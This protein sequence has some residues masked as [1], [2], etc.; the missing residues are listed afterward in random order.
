MSSPLRIIVIGGDAAGM[1]AASRAR[2]YAP[3]STV[4]VYEAGGHVSYSACGMPFYLGGEVREFD[5]LIHYPVSKFVEER[6]INVELHSRVVSIDVSAKM[7]T[8]QKGNETVQDSYDRLIIASGARPIVPEMFRDRSNVYTLR[9]IDDLLPLEK[10]M[11][12]VQA[13]SIIGAGYVGLEMAEALSKM[14][15]DVTIIQRS[16]RF[17]R[18]IDGDFHPTISKE[19]EANKV[20]L[21]LNSPIHDVRSDEGRVVSIRAGNAEV[22][23]D[24]V[25]VATGVAPNSEFAAQAGIRTGAGGA[26]VVNERM[27]TSAPMVFAAG[28]VATTRHLVTGKDVYFPLATGSNK[29]GRIAGENAAGRRSVYNGI[30][31]TEVVKVFSLEVGR[32]GLTEEEA[33]Q[34]RFRPVSAAITSTSRA[35]YYPGSASLKIK[36]IADENTHRLLGGMLVGKEGVAKR[37]DVLATALYARMRIEDLTRLDYSYSPPFSPSWEPLGVA[38]DVLLG[39]LS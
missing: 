35:S 12:N 26:I 28:D 16:E 18:G 37:L 10:A 27:Q 19:L 22:H 32:T 2:K 9:H 13:V 20:R 8:V 36:L 23:T 25:F 14:G 7:I 3:D 30:V 21:L 17:L 33:K 5:D 6:R 11:E 34:N 24:A 1:S 39:K 29:S 4:V 31:G 15:K 38:A